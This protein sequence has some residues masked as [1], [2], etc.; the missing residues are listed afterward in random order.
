MISRTIY[1][2]LEKRLFSGKALIIIGPRQVGKTTIIKSLL[3]SHEPY[4]FLDGDDPAVRTLLDTPTTEEIKVILENHKVIF[5]DEAQRIENIGLTLKIIIDQFPEVQVVVSGSSSFD[6]GQKMNEPLTGRKW[7]YSLYP[8][9]W[10][11]W[12]EEIGRLKGEQDFKNRLLYGMYPNVLNNLEEQEAVLFQLSESYLY[13]DILAFDG[14]RKPKLLQKLV[15]ALALQIG[16]EVVYNEVAQLVGIDAKTVDNYID[17]LEKAFIVFRLPAF[18]R[19]LRNEIKRNQKIY[20]WDCGI[21]NAV[22]GN[23]AP[24]ELRNDIGGLWENFLIS[25]RMKQLAYKRPFAKS[26]FW[27]TT[28]QQE[29]DYIEDYNGVVTGFEFKWNPK[30]KPRFPK[31]FVETYQAQTQI[32]NRDNFR[33][34]VQL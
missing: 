34:F 29:V 15:Q 18:S 25:E 22:I 8:I 26:Y 9:S 21:R 16:Q 3:K 14:I 10:E 30:K 31:T 20:F 32:V 19:N 13:K 28:Q 6:L 33:D 12:E 1:P 27:R 2:L 5:V 11:E 4:L 7:E 17:I 24:L 23:F